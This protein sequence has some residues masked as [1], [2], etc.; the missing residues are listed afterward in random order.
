MFKINNFF[1]WLLYCLLY[2]IPCNVFASGVNVESRRQSIEKEGVFGDIQLQ[3]DLQYGNTSLIDLGTSGLIGFRRKRHTAFGFG[4]FSFTSESLKKSENIQKSAMGHLRYNVRIKR[5]VYWEVFTQAQNDQNIFVSLR[6]L[7]GIGPRFVPI[8]NDEHAVV[9]GTSYMSEYEI[10]NR[11]V[12]IPYPS[13]LAFR[14]TWVHRWS[15]YASYRVDITDQFVF[16]T[17]FYLQPRFDRFS[18]VKVFSDNVLTM[19]INN[20]LDFSTS[21][22][23]GFDNEPPTTCTD[24]G[25]GK[26]S[27]VD[28]GTQVGLKVTF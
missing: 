23:V 10:L 27:K 21:L 19:S 18:D 11:G 28:L 24:D 8:K 4:N 16:Q 17:T 7:I 25:C 5:W 13:E 9:L 3:G 20:R 26:I 22:G 14:K 2:L 6:Y 1:Y 12:E 15:N